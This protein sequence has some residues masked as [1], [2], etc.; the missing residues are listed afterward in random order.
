MDNDLLV[1]IGI[2][3]YNDAQYLRYAIASVLN[4]SYHNW[5]LIL[6][7]DGSCDGSLEIARSFEDKRIRIISDGL[8]KGLAA[9]LNEI[10]IEAK[11]VYIARM[12]ADDIMTTDRL[13]QQV[14][15]LVSHPEVDI[16]GSSAMIINNKNQITYSANQ[17]GID[18]WYI[19]PSI[20]GKASWFR[21]NPYNVD[22]KRCQDFELWTRTSQ[23]SVFYN[24]H[25]PLLFY[26][27]QDKL[28][29][30]KV[31]AAFMA[32]K[33]VFFNYRKYNRTWF[34]SFKKMSMQIVKLVLYK[35]ADMMGMMSIIERGRWR[36]KL[37]DD[38]LLTNAD[39]ENCIT[40]SH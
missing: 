2:P 8:N 15:Y 39:L 3:F 4:Q 14:S 25:R 12:D 34:W 26:R 13:E 32:K 5:E 30:V 35:I 21:S 27:V 9:R 6:M 40:L 28:S 33:K 20:M 31:Y 10:A 17:A 1:T 37:P 18:T 38:L 24:M 29:Y 23:K 11:G 22:F 36:R 7:D 19:H 16:V